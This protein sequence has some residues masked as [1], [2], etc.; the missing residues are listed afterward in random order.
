[1]DRGIALK[2]SAAPCMRSVRSGSMG[3]AARLDD[4]RA[5]SADRLI[6]LGSLSAF[7]WKAMLR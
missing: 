1:M 3:F 5:N 7:V 4:C 6:L 2:N